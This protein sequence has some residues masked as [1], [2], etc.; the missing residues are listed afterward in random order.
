MAPGTRVATATRPGPVLFFS[1]GRGGGDY[2]YHIYIHIPLLTI[3]KP[4]ENGGLM[5]LIG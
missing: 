4:W 3:G 1:R 2:R 5:G